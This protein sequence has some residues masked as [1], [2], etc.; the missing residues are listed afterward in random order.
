MEKMNDNGLALAALSDLKYKVLK[1]VSL[2]GV[3]D[4]FL[5]ETPV[6]KQITVKF[7]KSGKPTG[8]K[9]K[10]AQRHRYGITYPLPIEVELVVFWAKDEDIVFVVPLNWLADLLNQST[11]TIRNNNQWEVHITFGDVQEIQPTGCE[12]KSLTEFVH[13]PKG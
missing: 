5:M 2:D 1:V 12:P 13:Y 6:G 3:E 11:P 8:A 7:H 9:G 4:V 10:Q